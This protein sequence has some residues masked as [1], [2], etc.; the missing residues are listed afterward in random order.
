MQYYM[1]LS[2]G[3]I[4]TPVADN[5]WLYEWLN[6]SFWVSH[7]IIH[8]VDF[9]RILMHS[10]M[11]QVTVIMSESLHHSLNKFVLKGWFIH[12]QIKSLSWVNRW[13]YFTQPS[14]FTQQFK[15]SDSFRNNTNYFMS[16]SLTLLPNRLVLT[17][18]FI[19]ELNKW[20]YEWITES[21]TYLIGF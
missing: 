19:K 17:H 5:K 16:D 15:N 14:I 9:F 21:F 8:S 7:W 4:A 20:L 1:T 2:A 3:Y 18:W 10:G 13:I 11:K 6:V 12:K